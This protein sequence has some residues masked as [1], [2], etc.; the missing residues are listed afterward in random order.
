MSCDD[1]HANDLYSGDC[2]LTV[3]Y[4]T[5]ATPWPPDRQ[6]DRQSGPGDINEDASHIMGVP[7]YTMQRPAGRARR[8]IA[9]SA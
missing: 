5:A 7:S 2:Q 6:T 3:T 4:I 8:L 1:K 9:A